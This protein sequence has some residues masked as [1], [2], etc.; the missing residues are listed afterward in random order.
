LSAQTLL[1]QEAD[2]RLGVDRSGNVVDTTSALCQNVLALISR[3]PPE[4]GTINDQRVSTIRSAYINTALSDLSGI[5]TS[6]RYDW[7]MGGLGH[8]YLDFS[9]ALLL[10]N[11]YKQ[12]ASDDF[13][14][15]RNDLTE[16]TQ[17]SRSKLSLA[18]ATPSGDWRTTV[19]GV[20]LGS[21]GNQAAAEFVD[22]VT[23]AHEGARL[24][25]WF[26]WNMTIAKK[27]GQHID[28][29]LTINNLANAQYRDDNSNLAYPFFDPYIGADPLGRRYSLSV[30]YKF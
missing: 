27:W 2:C 5:D 17:R 3:L 4:P 24:A 11:R 23:G 15:Y 14:D 16:N 18:W 1:R 13:H 29:Q 9:H 26:L 21:N 6:F 10:T 30:G 28:S 12:F 25:P 7:Q 20:R 8:F 19:T 22:A